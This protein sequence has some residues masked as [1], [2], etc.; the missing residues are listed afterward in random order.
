MLVRVC[1]HRW[2]GISNN[3]VAHC[4]HAV[5]FHFRG[6]YWYE[7]DHLRFTVCHAHTT[8]WPVSVLYIWSHA[9]VYVDASE[10]NAHPYDSAV[11]FKTSIIVHHQAFLL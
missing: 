6:T 9:S 5:D 11:M 10:L 2:I 4:A 7:F 8:S 3:C 1:M